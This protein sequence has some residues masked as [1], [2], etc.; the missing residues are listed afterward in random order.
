MHVTFA[1][2]SRCVAEK[3]CHSANGCL[4]IRLRLFLGFERALRIECNRRQDRSR[5]RP[6]IFCGEI[7]VRDFA[8][9]IVHV[10][11]CYVPRFAVIADVLEQI[12]TWQILALRNNSR[13]SPIRH[14]HFVLP[15]ALSA[16]TKTQ[17]WSR[18]GHTPI[19]WQRFG[20]VGEPIEFIYIAELTP[21]LVITVL[22][23]SARITTCRLNMASRRRTNPDIRPRRW[24]RQTSYPEETLLLA[25]W[26]ALRI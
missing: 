11:R 9:I 16:K 12:L 25:D 18:H 17:V 23:P 10:L 3:L 13:G 8:Q 1:T 19:L 7:L 5:P 26:F 4:H 21:T 6:E 2:N 22:L 15:P 24:N 20:K 14:V